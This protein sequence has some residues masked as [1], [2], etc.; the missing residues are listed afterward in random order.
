[1]FGF[2][3]P[4]QEK[5]SL[6]EL[7]LWHCFNCGI[8]HTFG[9]NSKLLKLCV[10]SDLGF[11]N[12]WLH[13][14][15][16]TIPDFKQAFC[17]GS[18]GKHNYTVPDKI[19]ES[20]TD[21]GLIILDAKLQDDVLDSKKQYKLLYKHFSKHMEKAKEKYPEL[22]NYV[23]LKMNEQLVL[24]KNLETDLEKITTSSAEILKQ[25]IITLT[26]NNLS[27]YEK[28]LF[29]QLGRWVYLLDAVA[30]LEEDH[31][32]KTFNPLLVNRN[33]QGN[34]K[35]FL[36]MFKNK[37]EPIFRK[38]LNAIEENYGKLETYQKSPI[39]DNV[40]IDTPEQLFKV[41][42]LSK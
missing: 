27:E 11:L 39:F 18:V 13:F 30:D 19:S 31:K 25:V 37:I 32:N 42:F 16:K 6:K 17:L 5:L 35:Q 14:H 38:T 20:V 22:T 23:N 36:N 15:Y 2:L 21:I 28:N 40:L 24:E 12:M 10:N 34:K 7:N 1:M 29:Y 3:L 41:M 9:K 26:N 33:Y 8:C 4:T